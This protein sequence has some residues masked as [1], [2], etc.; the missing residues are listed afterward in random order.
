[1]PAMPTMPAARI[2]LCIAAL[3][4]GGCASAPQESFYTLT[5]ATPPALAQNRAAPAAY[6]I[7]VGPVHVPEIVDR[8]QLVVRKGANQVELLEQHRWAQPLRAEIAQ[9]I[10][11]GMAARL[12]QARVAFDNDAAS[13]NAD[14]RISMDVKR[15]EALPGEAALVQTIWT[16]RANADTAPV[17][18]QST[19]RAPVRGGGYDALAA[20]FGRA[21]AQVSGEIADAVASARASAGK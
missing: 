13:R 8:P 1:M 19:V 18:S 15:F 12:P 2:T 3:L 20:A 6:S 21:L 7:A 5:P 10:A 17:V 14:Y 4:L 9:A 11:A 16:V